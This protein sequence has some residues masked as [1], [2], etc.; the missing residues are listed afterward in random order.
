MKL[1][2]RL[3]IHSIY[4]SVFLMFTIMSGI[5]PKSGVWPSL[6]AI[7]PHILVN[8]I[9]AAVIFYL[10]Y[11][12]FIRFFEKR[13]LVRYLIFSVVSSVVITFVFLPVHKYLFQEFQIFNYRMF[14][15]PIFGTFIIG[16]TGCLV[17]GFENWFTNVPLKNELENR[18]LRNELELLKSQVNPHFLFN[19]LNNIDS[20]IL[21]SPDKASDSLITL[22]EMLRYMI[23]ETKTEVVPLEN[24]IN[25]IRSYIKLQNLR[26]RS[27]EYVEYH[28]P[29]VCEDISIAPLLLIPVIENAYKH[30]RE[31]N[32]KP[33]IFIKLNCLQNKL[34]FTCENTYN[35][36]SEIQKSGGIGLENFTRRLQLIYPQKHMLNIERENGIFKLELEIVLS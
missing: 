20:L 10:F 13:L 8:W 4:W 34:F 14:L 23:Y 31:L 6:D 11:F 9:W 3:F 16:Q 25:Y 19:T 27:S 12:Y 15:P 26:Y 30:S 18:N 22:S 32:K 24:E 28:F 35:S 33:V 1:S 36:H 29:E 2:L 7:T 17:R 21:S 5:T